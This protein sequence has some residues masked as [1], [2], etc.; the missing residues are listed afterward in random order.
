MLLELVKERL[1]DAGAKTKVKCV[2]C[3][4][5]ANGVSETGAETDWGKGWSK[6][7]MMMEMKQ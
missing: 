7:C 6:T 4:G 2:C 5:D 1:E 3:F